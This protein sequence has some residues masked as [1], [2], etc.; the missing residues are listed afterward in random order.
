[1]GLFLLEIKK[2][3]PK[4]N[5]FA[6]EP[7]KSMADKCRLNNIYVYE[8]TIEKINITNNKFDMITCFELFEHL[9]D[10]KFFLKKIYKLLNKNGIF[11]FT[12]LNGMGFDI[13]MLG[14]LSNSIY[15]PYH[16]NFFNPKS[17]E[18][19]LKKIGF[20][21]LSIE[22]PGKLDLSIVENNLFLLK[23]KK[24]I[25][26]EKFIKNENQDYKDK[27]QKYLQLNKLS[28]HMRIVVKK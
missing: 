9:Y 22:T 15:P 24:K 14:K 23:G 8:T 25:F 26:F 27:F 5:L 2:K 28:S 20:D 13:Q 7:S 16:I 1:M 6:I 21:I 4:A 18:I 10:P 17:I 3:W 19:L 12:T 11:Y